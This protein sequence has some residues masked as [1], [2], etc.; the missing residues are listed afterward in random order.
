MRCV[1]YETRAYRTYTSDTLVFWEIDRIRSVGPVCA[2]KQQFCKIRDM[3]RRTCPVADGFKF[4]K[5]L[6]NEKQKQKKTKQKD[7]EC[8]E[9]KY[10]SKPRKIKKSRKLRFLLFFRR[11]EDKKNASVFS[12]KRFLAG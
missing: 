6:E 3:R 12:N 11:L 8:G 7:K 10:G 2:S 9:Y 4:L 1:S 5:P